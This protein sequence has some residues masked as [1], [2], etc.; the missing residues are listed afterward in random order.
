MQFFLKAKELL[1]FK[2]KKKSSDFYNRIK[3]QVLS[4]KR[5]KGVVNP[6]VGIVSFV[7]DG[8]FLL[9]TDYSPGK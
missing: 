9:L 3:S 2:L 6:A 8:L 4:T 5:K 7:G 1:S